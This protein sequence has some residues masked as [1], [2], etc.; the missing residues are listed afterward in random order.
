MHEQ[1]LNPMMKRVGLG[2]LPTRAFAQ[3]RHNG[4]ALLQEPP[5]ATG[6]AQTVYRTRSSVKTAFLAEILR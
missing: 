1:A 6:F 4:D 5:V 2:A 3:T